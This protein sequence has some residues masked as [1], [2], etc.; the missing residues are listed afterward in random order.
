MRY[1]TDETLQSPGRFAQHLDG[2]SQSVLIP[3]RCARSRQRAG[4]FAP[5]W[6]VVAAL[7]MLLSPVGP[8][9]AGPA[10]RP[11]IPAVNAKRG[12]ARDPI[13][14]SVRMMGDAY[15]AFVARD[16][17]RAYA[18]A[19]RID[20]KQLRNP[21]YAIYVLAQSAALLG[22][23]RIALKHFRSLDKQSGSRFRSLARWR[24][25]DCLWALGS[26][27]E[28]RRMYQKLLASTR[29]GSRPDG[30]VALAQFRIALAD[31]RRGNTQAAIR[32]LRS[33][34]RK[35]PAHPLADTADRKLYELGG[36]SAAGI[37]ASDRITRA[38][39]LTEDHR[40]HESIAELAMVG[41]QH[42]QDI[43][44]ERDYWT[45][46]TLFKMRRRYRDAGD[47]LLRIYKNLDNRAAKALFHGA[48]ALSRAD[49]DAD[50]VRWYQRLVAEYPST[51]WAQEAQFL[52]GWLEFNMG[53]YT[54]AVP[55]LEH[56]LAR[57]GK[58]KWAVEAL[59]FLGFSNYLLGRYEQALP[60]FERLGRQKKKLIGGK[61]QYWYARTL[62]R[63]DRASQANREYRELVSRF[64]FSW[65]AHLARARLAEKGISLDPFGDNKRDPQRAP[66][67]DEKIDSSL[68][69]TRLIRKTDELLAAG[70]DV[71]A[72][73]E[74]RRGEKAFL[75][76]YQRSAALA[77]LLDQYRRANNFNRPYMLAI[78][79]GGRRALN[80]EPTGHARVWWQHAYPLAYRDLVEKWRHLGKNPSYYLYAIMRKESAFNPHTLSYADAIGLLQMIPPTTKRVV[81]HLDMEYTRDLLYDPALNIKTGS[82]YIGR[83]LQKFKWQI[84]YGAG[85]YN[86]G[87]RPV[88]RWMD[89]FGDRPAD[90]FVE[91]V[92]YRQT[93][94][95]MKKVTETYSRYLYLYENTVYDL[96]LAVDRKYVKNRLTY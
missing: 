30:D 24:V 90:E 28:A 19:S 17:D 77:V 45:A 18:V 61:G 68:T 47:I 38:E 52:S 8:A 41:D 81:R 78:V 66:D 65:Y 29:N 56:M 37:S 55:H 50:A 57:Y 40:W 80:A 43:V 32:E 59:W 10:E 34:L 13:P 91:L 85:S 51:K 36:A 31:A 6:A 82:W 33:F 76:R 22:K 60:L 63:L 74:L 79:H 49:F 11:D 83:L 27:S 3:G 86:S 96:P 53:N 58:S 39:R 25:A 54:A 62:D 67:I 1:A 84:P 94:G 44:R 20:H 12:S 92:P 95:Y 46:M 64:P 14:R 4:V 89:R 71:E 23:H 93:R 42:N 35:H 75:K 9:E 16:F 87:P 72:G 2:V 15:R 88:M 21:D 69:R 7:A 5:G 48:R 73:V 70:L 26:H